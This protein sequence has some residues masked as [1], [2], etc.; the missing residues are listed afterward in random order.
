MT[1]KI[2]SSASQKDWQDILTFQ[3]EEA[4]VVCRCV[5]VCMCVCPCPPTAREIDLRHRRRAAGRCGS[6]RAPP[7]R[8][9]N[10]QHNH[11]HMRYTR[12]VRQHCGIV[13]CWTGST[14]QY[15]HVWS[16]L[17]THCLFS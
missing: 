6:A 17:F 16:D 2:G 10:T 1:L 9:C 7:G 11:R 8:P 14:A 3:T 12:V 15:P 5:C 4:S 13:G